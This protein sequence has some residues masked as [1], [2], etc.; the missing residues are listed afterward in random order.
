MLENDNDK[1]FRYIQK[2][3][4]PY[5]FK[6]EKTFHYKK[7]SSIAFAMLGAILGVM[8]DSY[9]ELGNEFL[10]M[11]LGMLVIGGAA[12]LYIWHRSK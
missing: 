5:F 3:Q 4:Q 7:S 11:A 8:L 12:Y 1:L 10:L 9:F 6:I 2:M